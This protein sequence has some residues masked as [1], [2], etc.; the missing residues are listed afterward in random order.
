MVQAKWSKVS[1]QSTQGI[2]GHG[3]THGN[4]F[5][6]LLGKNLGDT[7]QTKRE[8]YIGNN[9]H[10]MRLQKKKYIGLN[11]A[12]QWIYHIQKERILETLL[13]SVYIT[14]AV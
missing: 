4:R 12:R 1:G 6:H 7:W 14:V 5:N 10:R 11:P 13:G 8:T 9:P 3:G 2:F